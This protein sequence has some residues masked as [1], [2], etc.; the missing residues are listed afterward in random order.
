MLDAPFLLGETAHGEPRLLHGYAIT[1][2]V[3]Q[4][5]TV[6]RAYVLADE[7]LSRE[8]RTPR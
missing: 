8:W 4:G 1:A 6:D 2:H 5:S 7:G 3:A